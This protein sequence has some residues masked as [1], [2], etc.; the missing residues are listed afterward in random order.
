MN[1][2]EKIKEVESLKGKIEEASIVILLSYKGL[3]ANDFNDLRKKLKEKDSEVKVI[4]NRL[5]KLAV[6]GTENETLTDY[7][8]GTTA[9][10]VSK[11]DPTA[12]AKVL[13]DFAKQND[14]IEITGGAISGQVVSLEEIKE[15]ASMPSREELLAKLLGSMQAPMSNLVSVLSQIPRQVVTVL[16]AVRDQK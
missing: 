14:K 5:A 10:A 9:M 15:L 16:S 12:P 3:A 4:K 11:S 1:K 2:A 6:K 13:S 7:F 8:Q